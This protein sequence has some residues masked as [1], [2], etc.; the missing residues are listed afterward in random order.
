MCRRNQTYV[1]SVEAYESLRFAD[2]CSARKQ[3]KINAN[4]QMHF[5]WTGLRQGGQVDEH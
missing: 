4:G 3:K 2:H 1:A 5:S